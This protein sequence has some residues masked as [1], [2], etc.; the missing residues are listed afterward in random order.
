M[1]RLIVPS[2]GG[3]TKLMRTFR[4]DKGEGGF[5]AGDGS[6]VGCSGETE[7]KG[8]CSVVGEA[9]G[10]VDS[11]AAVMH[12]NA[13]EMI[14]PTNVIV[15]HLSIVAPVHVWKNIVPPFAI[16]QKFFIDHVADKLIVQTV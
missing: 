12:T 1:P 8:D 6:G 2:I 5:S 16:A 13:I 10:V 15:R 3:G 7:G 14:E 9:I 11:C 4:D